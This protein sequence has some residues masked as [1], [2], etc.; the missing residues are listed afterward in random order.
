[1]K[2]FITGATGYL[3]FNAALALRR[4]GHKVWGLTRS[5]EK[6]VALSQNEIH[7]VLG[8]MQK[9]ATYASVMEQCSV[10]IHAAVDYQSGVVAPDKLLIETLLN[11]ARRGAQP[12]TF[13]YTSGVWVNGNT[14]DQLVDETTPLN[15]PAQVAWRPGHEQMVLQASAIRGIVFRPGCVYGKQGGLTATWFNGAYHEN[16][17]RVVGEGNNRW[18]MVH[19]DD[20]AEAYVRAAESNY[21]GEIFNI[22][23]HSRATVREIATAIARVSGYSGEIH[24]TPV[25]EATKTMGDLAECLA[26]D[27]HIDGRKA[28]RLL[29]WQPKHRGLADDIESYFEA[30]K[31]AQ[32]QKGGEA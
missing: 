5:R 9:P 20:L 17:L 32:G 10:L 21:G 31:A 19:V 16:A 25:A 30:W 27:Q 28:M 3:G 6:A 12:K 15:P 14:G 29:G 11:T 13:I 22:I 8:E 2:V 1:M 7:P 26:L 4:A 24:Y 18:A 23:D